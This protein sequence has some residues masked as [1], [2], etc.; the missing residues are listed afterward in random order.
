MSD[1]SDVSQKQRSGASV[2]SSAGKKNDTERAQAIA[3]ELL[4]IGAVILRPNDPFTWSSGLVAPI[5]CDNRRTLAYPNVRRVISKGFAEVVAER[6][7]GPSTIAGTATAGIPHA[8]WLAERL[9]APMAYVRSA[10]KEHGRGERIEGDVEA[11]DSVIV[12]EDL[13][14]T[15]GSALDAVEALREAGAT[16]RAVLSIFTYELDAAAA[17]FQEAD[18]PRHVLTTFS[19]LLEVARAQNELTDADLEV[20]ER[21]RADPEAWSTEHGGPRPSS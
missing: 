16:V 8:A 6:A 11:G 1:G 5:Y 14:S 17:S 12:V 9:D 10:A 2:R 13:I 21:W 19:T 20:L 4:S 7:L 15:G 18:V 3:R